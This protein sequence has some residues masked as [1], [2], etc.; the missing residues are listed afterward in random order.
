MSTISGR[1]GG[2]PLASGEGFGSPAP[3]RTRPLAPAVRLLAAAPT[4]REQ[5]HG[6]RDQFAARERGIRPT[7]WAGPPVARVSRRPRRAGTLRCVAMAMPRRREGEIAVLESLGARRTMQMAGRS[8]TGLGPSAGSCLRPWLALV[9]LGCPPRRRRRRALHVPCREGS[10]SS[11]LHPAPGKLV[12]AIPSV[13]AGARLLRR[14]HLPQHLAYA[15]QVFDRVPSVRLAGWY[16][17]R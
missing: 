2:L 5:P 14:T 10:T 7:R 11:D 15:H 17:H 12:T 1:P 8:T 4:A 9:T 16:E 13:G 3:R 6:A